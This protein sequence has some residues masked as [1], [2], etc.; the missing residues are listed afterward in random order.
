MGQVLAWESGFKFSLGSRL[1][2]SL[3]YFWY[4][5][6]AWTGRFNTF[7]LPIFWEQFCSP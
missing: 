5:A 3:I 6:V 2:Q 4:R 1:I 7:A